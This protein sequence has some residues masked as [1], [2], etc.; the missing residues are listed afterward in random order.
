MNKLTALFAIIT[1][2]ATAGIAQARDLGPDEALPPAPSEDYVMRGF[3]WVVADKLAGMP[4]P[5]ARGDLDADLAFVAD[6]VE[7]L[8]SLVEQEVV[9]TAAPT[10]GLEVLHLPV[11]DFTA[12]T[13]S[14]RVINEL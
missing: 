5:G 14:F 3:S 11:R 13:V 4:H 9:A 8:V 6:R 7:V 1:L 12:P 10:Y 2:A